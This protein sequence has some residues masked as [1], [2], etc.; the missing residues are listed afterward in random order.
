MA[1]LSKLRLPQ[2]LSLIIQ[3]LLITV[4]DVWVSS[5]K[6]RTREYIAELVVTETLVMSAMNSFC[7]ADVV[8]HKVL[9]T[10][11]HACYMTICDES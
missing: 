10:V 4:E 2:L 7:C 8:S 9:F 5:A 3:V 6:T 11:E 1:V